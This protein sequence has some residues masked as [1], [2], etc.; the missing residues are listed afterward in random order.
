MFAKII[1]VQ[2][3][4]TFN[5]GSISAFEKRNRFVSFLDAWDASGPISVDPRLRKGVD[6]GACAHSAL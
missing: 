1:A 4:C 5:L 6:E 3:S 2:A